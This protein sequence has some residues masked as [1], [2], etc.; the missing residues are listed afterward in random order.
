MKYV[1]SGI[2]TSTQSEVSGDIDASS[3]QEAI[4]SLTKMRIEVYKLTPN[5]NLQI[6]SKK[7]SASDLVLPLQEL[8]TLC[9]SGVPLV[10]AVAALARNKEHPGLAKGFKKITSLIEGGSSFSQA[11]EESKLPFPPYVKH[12]ASSGEL[13]GN[14]AQALKNAS[15]QLNYEQALRN[16]FKSALTYPLVLIGSGIAAMLIIF[17]AVV[18]KFSHMLEEGKELPTLAWLVLKSGAAVNENPVLV[19]G[20]II[21][22]ILCV[23]GVFMNSKVRIATLNLALELPVIGPWLSEQ[24]TARWASLCGAMLEAKVN[25]V[26]ALK[27]SAESS[28]FEKRR[29]KA[30]QLIG[31]VQSGTSLTEALSQTNLVPG[32]SLNLISVGD[33]TGRLAQMMTAVAKLHDEACKRKMKQVLTL[34]EPVAILVVGV[35]IGIMILGI[36]LAITSSTDIA[37]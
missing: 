17:F 11:I 24:D 5:E 18:P 35:M 34:V 37:I 16:D 7:V 28:N 13:S 32:T 9:E 27:L 6:G 22:L 33:K 15:E 12:L 10:D 36:V 14:L 8:S 25:L 31:D 20:T 30:K 26:T 1:Y 2:D 29:V 4:R 19:L 23:A 3:E 21:V